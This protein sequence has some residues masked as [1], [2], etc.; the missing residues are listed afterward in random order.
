MARFWILMEVAQQHIACERCHEWLDSR[1]RRGAPCK[2]TRRLADDVDAEEKAACDVTAQA[3][4]RE[5]DAEADHLGI[6]IRAGDQTSDAEIIGALAFKVTERL[7]EVKAAADRR[8]DR[9]RR[10]RSGARQPRR[11]AA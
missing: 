5:L 11:P 6:P 9:R 3:A 10:A 7:E 8:A 1:G 4:D 2:R